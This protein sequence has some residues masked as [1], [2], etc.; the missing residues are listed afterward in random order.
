MPEN[1]LPTI[2][3]IVL[4]FAQAAPGGGIA[5]SPAPPQRKAADAA[6]RPGTPAPTRTDADRYDALLAKVYAPGGPKA[7]R[8][9]SVMERMRR[10]L[11]EDH[12]DRSRDLRRLVDARRREVAFLARRFREVRTDIPAFDDQVAGMLIS[13]MFSDY[14]AGFERLLGN[15]P[16][17]AAT[18]FRKA[19]KE[20]IEIEKRLDAQ[21]RRKA[22]PGPSRPGVTTP[23]IRPGSAGSRSAGPREYP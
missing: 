13:T 1:L 18:A 9:E 6:T 4:L 16:S 15:N 12:R 3:L 21:R 20:R 17:R 8:L 5:P 19:E 2:L 11:R 22:S 10:V 23:E 14:A 7:S